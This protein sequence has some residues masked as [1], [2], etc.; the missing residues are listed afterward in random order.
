MHYV[1]N[2]KFF[3][4]YYSKH[5]QYLSRMNV[6]MLYHNVERCVFS[7]CSKH[8]Q[9]TPAYIEILLVTSLKLIKTHAYIFL[10]GLCIKN[11]S[12]PM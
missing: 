10:F 6:T 1:Y 12:K 8:G 7:V 2:D 5:L 3:A 11:N 4:T 9:T